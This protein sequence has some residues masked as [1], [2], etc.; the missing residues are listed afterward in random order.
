MKRAWLCHPATLAAA[1]VLLINDHVLKELWPGFV[2]GKLSDLAGLVVAAPLVSLVFARRADLA[3]TVLTGVVFAL[4]KTTGTGA[5]LASHAWTLVAGPSRILADPTDLLA[6]PALGLAWRIRRH[7]A[8]RRWTAV[9]GVP[10]AV[11]AVGATGP[12]GGPPSADNV[13]LSDGGIMVVGS[14]GADNHSPDGRT[15]RTLPPANPAP[16]TPTTPRNTTELTPTDAQPTDARPTDARP[17]DARPTDAVESEPTGAKPTGAAETAVATESSSAM[18]PTAPG[19]E[20]P[21][22]RGSACGVEFCYRIVAGRLKVERSADAGRTWVPAWEVSPGRTEW[23]K[24]GHVGDGRPPTPRSLA[25]AVLERPDG[26]VVVVANGP[27]GVVVRDTGGTWRRHDY[28]ADNVLSTGA[29]AALTG[30]GERVDG[31]TRVAI[32]AGL[33]TLLAG[34]VAATPELVRSGRATLGFGLTGVLLLLP[35]R[36]EGLVGYY[37]LIN[38]PGLIGAV[39]GVGGG[40]LLLVV[41]TSAALAAWREGAAG[42]SVREALCVAVL[43]AAGVAL[44][45][46]GWSAG[47]PDAYPAALALAGFFGLGIGAAGLAIVRRNAV[48]RSA[49]ISNTTDPSRSLPVPETSGR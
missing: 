36:Y 6:L 2:T 11:L 14:W 39:A 40:V 48:S 18:G 12:V 4:V 26:H 35:W 25:I 28:G 38:L 5:E 13:Y 44:P 31:E 19:V 46:R 21:V 3:A 8:P 30:P 47:W 32:L 45:F 9:V 17:T 43:V 42:E 24:R 23:L 16:E 15:W 41:L 27:D 1:L 20:V 49:T 33:W 7:E 29:A 34:L 10:L 37:W 22:P